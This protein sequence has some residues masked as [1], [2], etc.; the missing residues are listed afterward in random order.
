M[1]RKNLSAPGLYSLIRKAFSLIPDHRVE[2]NISYSLEETLSAGLAIFSFKC[3]S[4]LKFIERAKGEQY[5]HNVR[6]LFKISK[7]P[8]ETQLR[9]IIDPVM[10]EEIRPAFDNVLGALQRGND[11]QKFTVQGLYVIALDGTG[12]FSSS[13]T[14]C[15]HCL[16]KT[17]K[18]KNADDRIYHHQMLGASI[19]HPFFKQVIP[20]FP[21][22]IMNEDGATKNDC[23]RN[24]SKRWITKFRKHHPK[25]PVLILEDSLASNVPHLKTLQEENCRYITG[26]K[27]ADHKYLFEQFQ[28]NSKTSCTHKHQEVFYSG[29][30]VKKTTTKTYEFVSDLEI[31]K[32]GREFKTNLIYFTE[33]ISTIDKKGIEKNSKTTFS[34]VT[35]LEL[36]EKNISLI[37]ATARRRWAIENETFQTLKKTTD[38]NLEHNYGHGKKYL[39]INF[40]LLCVLAFL[41]DQVQEFS[42]GIYKEIL[43]KAG[44]KRGLWEDMRGA[45]TWNFFKDW[46]HFLE[47]MKA[48]FTILN[49]T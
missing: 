46:E 43:S 9:D 26:V 8:S 38:Y 30:K 41:I 12:Y 7:I 6:S 17:I 22:P 44:S 47:I 2:R 10:P 29:E 3:P 14:S 13:K 42:C 33:E 35:D 4:L 5:G 16:T 18:G 25:L 37:V 28:I 21:E 36:N 24:A 49:T 40:S 27:E 39:A 11:L 48:H 1:V 23:E 32:V 34:W 15:P 19:V 20:L 31:N 45:I